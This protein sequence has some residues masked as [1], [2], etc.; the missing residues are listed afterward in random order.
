V[1]RHQFKLFGQKAAPVPSRLGGL[2]VQPRRSRNRRVEFEHQASLFQWAKWAQARFPALELLHASAAGERR[3]KATAIKLLLM[4]VRKGFP[5]V[6]L[7]VARGGYIGLWVEMKSDN[8][9]LS[10]DQQRI[11]A[12]LEDEGHRYCVCRSWLDAKDAVVAYLEGRLRR[13]V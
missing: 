9:R 2:T 4:G 3:D 6:Q 12:R 5:D 13:A 10:E 8:G 1:K 11:K 7:P